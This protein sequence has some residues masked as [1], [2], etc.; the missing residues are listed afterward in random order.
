M[1]PPACGVDDP[2][3]EAVLALKHKRVRG[4]V[5]VSQLHRRVAERATAETDRELRAVEQREEVLPGGQV[6]PEQA[7]PAGLDVPFG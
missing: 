6:S 1:L 2:A 5:G 4:V 3:Q 7:A